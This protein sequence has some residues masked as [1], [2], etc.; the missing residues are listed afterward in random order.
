MIPGGAGRVP[1]PEYVANILPEHL[2][3]GRLSVV[4]FGPGEG[5]AILVR[6]PDG[7]VGVVDGCREPAPA[8][9]DGRGDPVRELLTRI[10]AEPGAPKPFKLRFVCL[11]HPHDDHY[12]G[13]GRLLDAYRGQVNSVWRAQHVTS[14][15]AEA[16]VAWIDETRGG[17]DPIP[18]AKK[19]RGLKRVIEHM[20]AAHD[21]HGASPE[22]LH[23]GVSLL[24]AVHGGQPISVTACGPVSA[25]LVQAEA[26]LERAILALGRGQGGAS[27]HDPNLTSGALL[28]RWGT[29]AVLLAGDLLLGT[30]PHSGWQRAREHVSC[31]VQVVNVAHHASR[32]AH[33]A[34]LW[35]QMEPALAIVT[36]FQ[37]ARKKQPPRPEEIEALA[38][39]SVVV[40]TS[41]PDWNGVSG[42]PCAQQLQ[43]PRL[44][45]GKNGILNIT[46]AS[47]RRN[48]VAVSLDAAG[49][50][51]RFVLAGAA[52]T[53]DMPPPSPVVP[54]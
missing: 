16:L 11:T 26:D 18:D 17:K 7:M 32:E 45:P 12:A 33:D 35:A 22:L 19:L 20:H 3:A 43:P 15:Y 50:I 48:A 25:D 28:L 34:V 36:P 8:D 47:A 46:S 38:R 31:K 6:L 44:S 21:R 37:H 1:K 30:G 13:L 23:G 49:N 52:D 53:Y 41:P 10:E 40:I 4:V 9:V 24:S 27:R 39:S 2:P 42:S 54:A 5:E 29:S 51:M 14:R